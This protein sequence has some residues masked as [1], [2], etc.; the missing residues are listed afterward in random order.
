MN[1]VIVNTLRA[2][3]TLPPILPTLAKGTE[4][5]IAADLDPDGRIITPATIMDAGT[6]L[7]G[8][9]DE[10]K[11]LPG[12]QTDVDSVYWDKLCERRPIKQLLAVGALLN[13]GEGKAAALVDSLDKLTPTQAKA[14]ILDCT[15]MG[16]LDVWAEGTESDNLK[17]LIAERKLELIEQQSGR[18]VSGGNVPNAP[19][20]QIAKGGTFGDKTT[21]AQTE[22]GGA[23]AFGEGEQSRA[24]SV[25][26]PSPSPAPAPAPSED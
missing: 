20:D 17:R 26:G 2:L 24:T 6:V 1:L 21:P 5:L 11:L 19:A 18:P 9:F 25:P 23:P 7:A 10:Q 4:V 14:A 16:V 3:I 8:G 22:G 13:K 15:N 12:Q